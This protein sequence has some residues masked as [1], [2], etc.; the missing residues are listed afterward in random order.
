MSLFFLY[1][2]L[3][4]TTRCIS[5]AMYFKCEILVYNTKILVL[6]YLSQIFKYLSS[7]LY[8]SSSLNNSIHLSSNVLVSLPPLG[9]CSVVH[10]I[11]LHKQK[12]QIV[13]LLNDLPAEIKIASSTCSFKEKPKSLLLFSTILFRIY[14][15]FLI[16]TNL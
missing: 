7:F 11:Y 2:S 4:G 12:L 8:L 13:N 16:R 3:L 1:L 10:C 9:K 6:T 15:L 5:L 14:M